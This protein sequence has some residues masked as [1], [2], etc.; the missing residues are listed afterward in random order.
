MSKIRLALAA[1]V[2]LAAAFLMTAPAAAQ[3]INPRL[4][5]GDY[6][7]A[8]QWHDAGWWWANHPDWVRRIAPPGGATTT[9]LVSGIR[10]VITMR[11]ARSGWL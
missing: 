3:L 11:N 2:T 8:R 9:M 4:G 1:L 7:E 10:P 5:L 6:D